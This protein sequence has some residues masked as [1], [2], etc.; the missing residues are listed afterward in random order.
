MPRRKQ[1]VGASRQ[2]R[3]RAQRAND[4]IS[5]AQKILGSTLNRTRPTGSSV[6]GG[7]QQETVEQFAAS[8]EVAAKLKVHPYPTQRPALN[9]HAFAPLAPGNNGVLILRRREQ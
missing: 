9:L 1:V 5:V 6:S 7:L 2:V 4:G 3:Q 8:Y